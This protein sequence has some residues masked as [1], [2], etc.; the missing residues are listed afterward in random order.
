MVGP[1]WPGTAQSFIYE[2]TAADQVMLSGATR[3][4]YRAQEDRKLVMGSGAK[5]GVKM[6]VFGY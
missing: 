4:R 1:Q 2:A 6:W 5:G 3:G